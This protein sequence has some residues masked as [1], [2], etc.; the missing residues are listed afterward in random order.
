MSVYVDPEMAWPRSAAWPYGAVS[1]MYADTPEELHAFAEL[2]GL[3]R[4]WCSDHTQPGSRLLH[5]DLTPRR[6]RMA[7]RLGALEVDRQHGL[8]HS[9]S[10]EERSE[11]IR[12]LRER[13]GR[14][15]W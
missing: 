12:T 7:I 8:A 11:E 14:D 13:T 1:H 5:Y 4:R 3:R 10:K 15:K 6:R 2:M 9:R